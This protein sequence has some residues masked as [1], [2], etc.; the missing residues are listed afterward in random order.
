MA[1]L[2]SDPNNTLYANGFIEYEMDSR[3]LTEFEGPRNYPFT[4]PHG[5]DMNGLEWCIPYEKI[6]R[7]NEL[8]LRRTWIPDT[9]PKL[10]H[11]WTLSELGYYDDER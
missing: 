6:D 10:E 3:F 5:E 11:G 7:F 9:R 1:G 2:Y 4:G 8:T